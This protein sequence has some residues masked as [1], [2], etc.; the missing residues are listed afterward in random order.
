MSIP[1]ELVLPNIIIESPRGD[2]Y[3]I[4]SVDDSIVCMNN[5]DNSYI[6]YL[7]IDTIIKT[8]NKVNV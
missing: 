2:K 8:Y 7:T 3:K 1:R 4:V 5:K 6:R